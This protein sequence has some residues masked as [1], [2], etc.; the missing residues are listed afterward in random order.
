MRELLPHQIKVN[1]IVK[2]KDRFALYASPGTGKTTM[3]LYD[4]YVNT[5]KKNLIVVTKPSLVKQWKEEGVEEME[6]NDT[7][8]LTLDKGSKKSAME[9]TEALNNDERNI[10]IVSYSS[11]WR[12]LELL[13]LDK[14]NTG[15]ILDESHL[16]KNRTSKQ[17]KFCVELARR[18]EWVR[19]LTG[20]PMSIGWEDYI[21]PL[22]ML[23]ETDPKVKTIKAFKENFMIVEMKSNFSSKSTY[24][25]VIGYK[26]LEQLKDIINRKSLFLN[27]EKAGIKLPEQ[28]EKIFYAEQTKEATKA[29]KDRTYG[30]WVLKN[31]GSKMMAHRTSASGFLYGEDMFGERVVEQFKDQNKKNLFKDV[32]EGIDGKVLVFYNFEQEREDIISSAKELNK[33]ISFITK[34]GPDL[35][36]DIIA[37][38]Y[39]TGSTG[40]NLQAINHTLFYSPTIVGSDYQQSL[41]RTHRIGQDKTCYYYHLITKGSLE[42]RILAKIKLNQDY[43]NEMFEEDMGENYEKE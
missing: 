27:E 33:T 42:E 1:E 31:S 21:I 15:L 36:G 40:L 38:H 32:V 11:A 29:L 19:L 2:N 28:I 9:L 14:K 24:E 10:F 43:T 20:T 17:S 39:V 30:E 12:I 8:A 18:Y 6:F 13:T 22:K 23:N 34:D 25:S 3:S 35:S 5:N 37:T 4:W 16:A 26:N 7:F 41:K